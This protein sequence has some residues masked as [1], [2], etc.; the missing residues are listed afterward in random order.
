VRAP[1]VPPQSALVNNETKVR[2]PAF[3]GHGAA[4]TIIRKP[5]IQN[6]AA[7]AI[8]EILNS[9]FV[10]GLTLGEAAELACGVDDDGAQNTVHQKA[11]RSSLN[12]THRNSLL[13][14]GASRQHLI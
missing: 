6:G 5:K 1:A 14:A 3:D 12:I 2:T 10:H 8:L 4:I 11:L 13:H 7:S 9:E